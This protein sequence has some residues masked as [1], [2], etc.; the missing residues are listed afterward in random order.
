MGFFE[1]LFKPNIE[2]LKNKKDIKGLLKALNNRD[3]NIRK[4]AAIAL[5]EIGDNDLIDTL[6]NVLNN[7]ENA[8]IRMEVVAALAKR[9]GEKVIKFL[10]KILENRPEDKKLLKSVVNLLGQKGDPVAIGCLTNL[11]MDDP[12]S[13]GEKCIFSLEEIYK[14]TKNPEAKEAS[15]KIQKKIEQE[16]IKK[17]KHLIN[18]FYNGHTID[19]I[20]SCRELLKFGSL[21]Y[22]PLIDGLSNSNANMRAECA[23][24]LGRLYLEGILTDTKAIPHLAKLVKDPSYDV[25]QMVAWSLGKIG[26]PECIPL[27]HIL[28]EDNIGSEDEKE[29]VR[30]AAAD[31]LQEIERTLLLPFNQKYG[32]YEVIWRGSSFD[33]FNF[34]TLLM[35]LPIVTKGTIFNLKN[36]YGRH[37]VGN[38][39][40]IYVTIK[41]VLRQDVHKA[42]ALKLIE[43]FVRPTRNSWKFDI[44]YISRRIE[45][46]T[47]Y[48]VVRS[49][50]DEFHFYAGVIKRKLFC[51]VKNFEY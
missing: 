19:A 5:V 15:L 13:W 44:H 16:K 10:I 3:L 42:K 33:D 9:G 46:I 4:E 43:C 28:I 20:N 41:D 11:G 17:I 32:G 2:K 45:M 24:A 47:P 27:L 21:A 50:E 14:K 29:I 25:R 37:F 7:D 51:P 49:G 1:L 8:D 34:K 22:Q 30:K 35:E 6:I 31:A 39:E 40:S 23:W 36:T 38:I 12:I 48:E 26:K 18:T